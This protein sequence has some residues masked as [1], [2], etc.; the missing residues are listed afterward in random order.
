MLD[1]IPDTLYLQMDNCPGQNKN[2]Y[3]LGFLCWLV[4]IGVFKKIKVSFLMVGHTHEDIDQVFSRFSSL[5]SRRSALTLTKLITAFERCYTPVPTGIR[6][7]RVYN[8]SEALDLENISGHSKPHAFKIIKEDA[9]ATIFWK[10]WST[11]RIWQKC[12]GTLLKDNALVFRKLSPCVDDLDM[13]RLER[14]VR[15]SY[16]YFT[17]NEDKQWWENFFAEVN[18]E[19]DSDDEDDGIAEQLLDKKRQNSPNTEDLEVHISDTEDP[20]PPVVIGKRRKEAVPPCTIVGMMALMD[21]PQYAGEWP[22]IGQIMSHEGDEVDIHWYGGS[23]TSPWKPCKRS[24]PGERGRRT[25]WV[26]K[27]LTS[28]IVSTFKLTG[29]GNIPRHIK[30]IVENY[31]D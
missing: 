3:I 7:D 12:E 20:I 1:K 27:C 23:K 26:E 28:H 30:D 6:T 25:D 16:R 10:K 24:V 29:S 8:I 18:E 14:D 2:R 9:K 15:G 19:Y 13:E 31:H 5:L 4:E 17:K 11:D 21:V 22:Q